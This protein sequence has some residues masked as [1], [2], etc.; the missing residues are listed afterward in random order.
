MPLTRW[1][2]VEAYAR[3]RGMGLSEAVHSLVWLGLR[4]EESEFLREVGL[5]NSQGGR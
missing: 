5:T 4:E 2:E 3:R 1:E